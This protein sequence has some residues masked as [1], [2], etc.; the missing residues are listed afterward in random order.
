MRIRNNIFVWVFF[1][2]IVPL[3]ILALGATYFSESTYQ[4]D[5]T[6]DV[7]NS[8]GRQVSEIKRHLESYESL[9]MGMTRAPAVQEFLPALR[10]LARGH[11]GGNLNVHRSRL[12]HYFEGFQ[13]VLPSAFILRLLDTNGNSIVKVS[14]QSRSAP[15]YESLSGLSYVE[16]EIISPEFKQQLRQLVWDEVT[17]LQLPHN[18]RYPELVAS[19]QLRDYVV[20]LHY[21]GL[22]VGALSL[23]VHGEQLDQSIRNA[24]RLFDGNVF[25][26]TNNPERPDNHGELI[27]DEEQDIT[28]VQQREG[29]RRVAQFYEADFME[30]VSGQPFGE[31]D[32]AD[33][34][35]RYFY[36]ELFPYGNLLSSWIIAT[37][38]E[39]SV[40]SAPFQRIRLVIWLC[41]GIAL[42]ISLLLANIGTQKVANPISVLA[43][44]LMA[45]ANGNYHGRIHQRQGIDEIDSLADAFNYMAD[46]LDH[47][48]HDRDKAENMMLQNAKLASIGQMAAGIGHELNNPL[49]NILSYAKLVERSASDNELAK[50]DI[51][52]LREEAIRASEIIKGILNFARQVPPKYTRFDVAEWLND[53]LALVRQMAKTSGVTIESQVD[54]FDEVEG[55]RGQLQQ[56]LVNLLLNA[57]QASG[58]D[59]EVSIWVSQV[60]DNLLIEVVDQGQGI[61]NKVLDRIYDPFFTTK[62]EGEGTGLGLSIS[63]GIVERHN[64]QLM[65]R[66]NEIGHGVTAMITLPLH[67]VTSEQTLERENA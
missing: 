11:S 20:P 38:I 4:R 12:N 23:T 66:N 64:G 61:D 27:Y 34:R 65:I 47:A 51:K 2:T 49:S 67:K 31:F 21:R 30:R 3:T 36:M 48:R 59:N 28:F 35:Y 50:K 9:A 24:P 6:D 43:G 29:D 62:A 55:D 33:G 13:T 32:S 1:A 41:A 56:A 45:Y 44:N 18:K 15:V 16:Q 5:V 19:L 26:V 7:A 54:Y 10:N 57:I 17:A 53:T 40:I 14:Q 25:I 46:T 8:L 39:Q 22:F 58:R 52:S 42:V 60:D 37:R 63:L